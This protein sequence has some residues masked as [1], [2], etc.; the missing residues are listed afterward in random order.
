MWI[1]NL[2]LAVNLYWI[3]WLCFLCNTTD[4]S[5]SPTQAARPEIPDFRETHF[6]PLDIPVIPSSREESDDLPDPEVPSSTED[7]IRRTEEHLDEEDSN[8]NYR[9]ESDDLPDPKVPS[10]TEDLIRR[11]E[12]HLDEEDTDDNY[13][14]VVDDRD[15][16]S[17]G[18]TSRKG[19]SRSR[20]EDS[21]N[22]KSSKPAGVS[23]HIEQTISSK[24]PDMNSSVE[25]D[26]NGVTHVVRMNSRRSPASQTQ[27]LRLRGDI[28]SSIRSQPSAV[29]APNRNPQPQVAQECI[30]GPRGYPGPKGHHGSFGLPGKPGPLGRKVG[31]NNICLVHGNII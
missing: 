8:D 16:A 10:S 2:H 27:L 29:P 24:A 28:P 7:H 19:T 13:R 18:A 26:N 15:D 30:P 5:T 23:P 17:I 1:W 20:S 4:S 21:T 9:E 25:L 11:T 14:E 6:E 3:L 31:Y 22:R 12:E